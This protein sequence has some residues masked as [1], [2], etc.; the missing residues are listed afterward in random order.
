VNVAA[1]FADMPG[2][3]VA[4]RYLEGNAGAAMR[5]KLD[6]RIEKFWI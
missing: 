6:H 1:A 3:S 4:G 2:K 5:A